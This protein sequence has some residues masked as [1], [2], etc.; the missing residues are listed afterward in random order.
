MIDVVIIPGDGIGP[1]IVES[2]KF[3]FEKALVPVNWIEAQAGERAYRETGSWLPDETVDLV[4]RFKLALKGP[5]TTPAGGG[6]RSVNVALR[7]RLGLFANVRPAVS[8]PGIETKFGNIDL[9]TVRENVEDTYS[10]IEYMKTAD[11]AWGIKLST[12][13]GA[14]RVIRYAFEFAKQRGRSKVTCVNKANIHKL[15]DGIFLET[16]REI[17]SEYEGIEAD[18]KFVDNAC[19]QIVSDPSRFDVIVTPNLYGDIISDLM[20]GLVGGLGVTPAANIGADCAVFEAV[21]GSAPDIAGKGIANPTA[22]ILSS[23]MLLDHAG[24]SNYSEYIY[25]GLCEALKNGCFT[26]DLGGD[27]T[28]MEFTEAVAGFFDREHMTYSGKAPSG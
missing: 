27:M 4:R 28:L 1:E 25:A 8:L 17:A 26:K 9:I 22:L 16:F 24:L 18:E 11:V 12:R 20:A 21:H 6:H 2:V 23:L 13:P 14:R 3:L 10:G 7:Q 19:M 15:T 5:T